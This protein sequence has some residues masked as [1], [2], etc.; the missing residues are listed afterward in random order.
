MKRVA[1]GSRVF[2]ILNQA[3]GWLTA[4]PEEN[5]FGAF[6]ISATGAR[7]CGNSLKTSKLSV[8]KPL[9]L[10]SLATLRVEFGYRFF[11]PKLSDS[12]FNSP[13]LVN[14]P[15]AF[16]LSQKLRTL[17]EISIFLFNTPFR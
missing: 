4:S 17:Y 13:L 11:Q 1:S 8:L 2:Q 12:P 5:I 6:V 9:R 7:V 14:R 3:T 15:V 10:N 16:G